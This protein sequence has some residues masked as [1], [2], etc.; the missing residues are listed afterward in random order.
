MFRDIDEETR[1]WNARFALQQ[2]KAAVTKDIFSEIDKLHPTDELMN[3]FKLLGL[4][5]V[6]AAIETVALKGKLYYEG[7]FEQWKIADAA[8]LPEA[9]KLKQTLNYMGKISR[10]E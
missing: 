9:E 6:Q 8:G 5:G 7:A 4:S 2:A 3:H 10:A 1:Q